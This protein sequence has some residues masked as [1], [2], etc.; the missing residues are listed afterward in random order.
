[1]AWRTL[2]SRGIRDI[3][4]D[5]AQ[6]SPGQA[7]RPVRTERGVADALRAATGTGPERIGLRQPVVTLEGGLHRWHCLGCEAVRVP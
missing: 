4:R 1:M 3:D 5:M 6:S 7:F 2:N